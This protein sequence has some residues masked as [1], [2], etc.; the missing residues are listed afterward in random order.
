[1]S[2]ST[3]RILALDLDGT[4]IRRDGTVHPDDLAAVATVQAIGVQ[5]SLVTGR[6]YSG[7]RALAAQLDIRGTV[8]CADGAELVDPLTHR[9]LRHRRVRGQAAVDL[10][11]RMSDDAL[12]L[13]VMARDRI[14][15]DEAGLE[16][17][18]YVSNWSKSMDR[19]SS[20]RELSD[21]HDEHGISAVVAVGRRPAV[22]AAVARVEGDDRYRVENF[23]VRVA[24]GAAYDRAEPLQAMMVHAAGVDKGSAVADLAE[25]A[26]HTLADVVAVGDWINDI[27]MLRAA[28]RSFAMGHAEPAVAAAA[29]DQLEA[30]GWSGG[31][32]AEAVHKVWGQ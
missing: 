3:P 30:A 6:L 18:R 11:A 13:F 16:L 12:A 22:A 27:P 4:L 24:P 5:V 1:M 23:E 32:V 10:H 14:A 9:V 26:G 31:G 29:T 7:V 2:E 20:T 17:V 28:G 15:Y 21:W 19:V 25:Q 8:V